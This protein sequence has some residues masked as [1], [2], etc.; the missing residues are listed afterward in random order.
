MKNRSVPIQRV[1]PVYPDTNESTAATTTSSLA[2]SLS[3]AY[4][5]S[6][7]STLTSSSCSDCETF[8]TQTA[9]SEEE[10]KMNCTSDVSRTETQRDYREY[11]DYL[12]LTVLNTKKQFRYNY[13]DDEQLVEMD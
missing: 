5:V 1:L 12:P 4:A 9:S 8:P 2:S 11:L 6:S 10:L 3:S 7:E 13:N